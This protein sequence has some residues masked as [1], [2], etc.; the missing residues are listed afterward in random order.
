MFPF[1]CHRPIS[2]EEILWKWS[3]FHPFCKLLIVEIFH[4]TYPRRWVKFVCPTPRYA[5]EILGIETLLCLFLFAAKNMRSLGKYALIWLPDL[6]QILLNCSACLSSTKKRSKISLGTFLLRLWT[7]LR[8]GKTK[9]FLW[10][11]YILCGGFFEWC[12]SEAFLFYVLVSDIQGH[13]G[14]NSAGA[15]RWGQSL[16]VTRAKSWARVLKT[17]LF[18]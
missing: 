16:L 3:K 5:R 12:S 6:L 7:G 14:T 8:F 10:V 2:V 15:P 9:T 13:P 4:P 11:I 18:Q 17:K 1:Q